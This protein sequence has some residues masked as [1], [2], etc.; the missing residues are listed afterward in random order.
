[1][2]EAQED[3]LKQIYLLGGEGVVSSTELARRLGVKPASVTG[4]LKKLSGLGLVE[5]V[6]YR[7]VRLTDVGKN[8]ALEV[9]RHHRLLETYLMQA[10]NYDWHEVHD[11]A[12]RLEH[13][14][15]ERF[16]ARIA[17]WLG[18][19]ERDPHGDPIPD[20]ALTLKE[21]QAALLTEVIPGKQVILV[22][23]IDQDC[24]TLNLFARLRLRP[25]TPLYV[26]AREPKGIRLEVEGER[27]L[28]PNSLAMQLRVKEQT[29]VSADE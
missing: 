28:L 5:Y 6:P 11:E 16:E 15:S 19:P 27:F 29:K 14:I 9:L 8:V 18:H 10:L 23:V 22:Q 3:Y 1:M 21:E 20:H 25:G 12:E 4:M 24:D 7:G 2:S 26:L 13:V 17:E